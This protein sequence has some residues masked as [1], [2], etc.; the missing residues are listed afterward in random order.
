MALIRQVVQHHQTK[1]W[2]YI[3]SSDEEKL[4]PIILGK[5]E[6]KTEAEAIE[7]SKGFEPFSYEWKDPAETKRNNLLAEKEKLE[8]RLKEIDNEINP[9]TP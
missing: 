8:K 4:I 6:F 2:A 1:L 3:E 5:K 9:A 7:W